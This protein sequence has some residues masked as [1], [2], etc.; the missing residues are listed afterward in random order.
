MIE[1]KTHHDKRLL[2]HSITYRQTFQ[3]LTFP[4]TIGNNLEMINN[5]NATSDRK[6]VNPF[7]RREVYSLYT[8]LILL[9]NSHLEPSRYPSYT[10]S[11]GIS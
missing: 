9:V 1:I 2:H 5:Y 4:Q 11:L 8:F 10:F 7:F 6:S 3:K